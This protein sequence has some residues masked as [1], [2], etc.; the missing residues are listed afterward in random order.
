MFLSVT[1]MN[2]RIWTRKNVRPK[3]AFD[4]SAIGYQLMVVCAWARVGARG[5]ERQ[6]QIRARLPPC[7]TH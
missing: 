5:T 2:L 1:R 6:L 3:L 7:Q 4:P